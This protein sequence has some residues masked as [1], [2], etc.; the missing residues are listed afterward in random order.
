[1][2]NFVKSGDTVTL[3]ATAAVESGA[4]VKVGQVIGVAAYS[5]DT[6]E[7]VEAK[8]T[9][10]FDLPKVAG[11]I[12]AGDPL[13]YVIATKNLTKTSAAGLTLVGVAVA[14]AGAGDATVRARLDGVTRLVV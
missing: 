2:K 11:A 12:S 10:V 13:Y 6:G 14:D 8:L 7:E 9:G 4:F 1:M 3:T 5:A